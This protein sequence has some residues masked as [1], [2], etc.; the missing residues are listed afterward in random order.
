MAAAVEMMMAKF[1]TGLFFGLVIGGYIVSENSGLSNGIKCS[2]T[3]FV[4]FGDAQ[5][6][7]REGI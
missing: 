5:N 6:C 7:P 4:A 3:D 2:S 1:F